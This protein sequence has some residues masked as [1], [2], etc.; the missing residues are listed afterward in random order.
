MS[1]GERIKWLRKEKCNLT[2]EEVGKKLGVNKATIQKYE[3]GIITTIPNKK[4]ELM[5]ELFEVDHGFILGWAVE[6]GYPGDSDID[7]AIWRLQKEKSGLT[8]KTS[9]MPIESALGAKVVNEIS[10]LS[11]EGVQKV[12]DY[13]RLV[14][15]AEQSQE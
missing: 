7:R 8:E 12:L 11:P 3:N 1:M 13:I 6:P 15:L 9:Q 4:I 10:T 5:A 2:Q 14:S